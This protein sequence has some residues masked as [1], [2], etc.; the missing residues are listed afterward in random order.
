VTTFQSGPHMRED[1]RMNRLHRGAQYLSSLFDSPW[2][3]HEL[4]WTRAPAI[5]A[6][7]WRNWD[8]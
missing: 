8:H 6:K 4:Q 3:V 2:W 1:G 5:L 7:K